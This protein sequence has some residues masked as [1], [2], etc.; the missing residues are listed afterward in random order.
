MLTG[1]LFPYRL[2]RPGSYWRAGCYEFYIR[3]AKAYAKPLFFWRGP[4]PHLGEQILR[5]WLR[6]SKVTVVLGQRVRW[7]TGRTD[8]ADRDGK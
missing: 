8:P 4:E 7:K 1:G 2:R 6:E 3:V 5:D